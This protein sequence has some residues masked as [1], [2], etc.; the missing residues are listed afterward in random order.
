MGRYY[1]FEVEEFY[2]NLTR[3]GKV[4]LTDEEAERIIG[5]LK[6]EMEASIYTSDMEKKMPEI[7]HKIDDAATP[8][9]EEILKDL[10]QDE[11]GPEDPMFRVWVPEEL[12]DR[13]GLDPLFC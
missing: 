1:T 7:Y 6:E 3:E 2:S 10:D 4:F 9:M 11:Y 13:A 12:I 8:L 5:L